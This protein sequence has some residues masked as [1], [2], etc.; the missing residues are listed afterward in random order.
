M[1][2]THPAIPFVARLLLSYV[3]LTSGISKATD[4][5]GNAAYMSAHGLPMVPVL[6]ALA[7]LIELGG[8]ACLI[9]G[10]RARAAALVMFV[11][12]VI[13]TLSLHNYWH[14]KPELAGMVETEFRKNLGILGGLLMVVY[15]GAGPWAVGKSSDTLP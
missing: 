3:F 6:L 2:P 1:K 7:T 12:L 15:A 13:V 10:Y 14:Y 9:T 11:Y 8:S 5:S 4:W